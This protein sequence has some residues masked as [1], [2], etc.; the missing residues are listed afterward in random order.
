MLHA[1]QCYLL[2]AM[3]LF[4]NETFSVS[5]PTP[6]RSHL[7]TG[8]SFTQALYTVF[9]LGCALAPNFPALVIFR[10]LCGIGASAPISVVGGMYADILPDPTTRGHAMTAYMAAVMFG[11]LLGPITSGFISVVSWR[12]TFWLAL[13]VA[14]VTWPFL[15]ACPE[16]YGPVI[17]KHRAQRLRKQ[18]NGGSTASSLAPIELEDRSIK[19]LVTVVLTRPLRMLIFEAIVL[20]SCVYIAFAYAIFYMFFQ[21]YPLIFTDIYGFNAGEEGLAFL[22]IGVGSTLGCAVHLYWDNFLH[23]AKSRDPPAPWTQKEEYRRLPLA[24]IG[25]PFFAIS[26]FWMGWT[27]RP[28]IHWIVPVLAGVPFGVGFLL[29]FQ[30]LLCYVVDAY[31]VFAASALAASSTSRSLFGAVLPFAA[32]PMYETLGVH[33]ACT[34]LGCLS[35]AMCAIPFAFIRFGDLLRARSG[36]CRYLAER[37]RLEVEEGRLRKADG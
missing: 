35:L 28:S 6:Q 17:L 7:L 22:A 32:R 3:S 4:Y 25:G 36:F 23:R 12:W 31:D 18:N 19:Q 27:A 21:A 34:V 30:G 29:I 26:L 10:F 2:N 15:L 33:W 37:K 8:P 24:I 1:G 11:P 20:S 9:T 14:G 16:T 13:I 5:T